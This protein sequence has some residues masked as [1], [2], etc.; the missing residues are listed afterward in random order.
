MRRWRVSNQK[1]LA[2]MLMYPG[3]FVCQACNS[4][5]ESPREL[6][7]VKNIIEDIKEQCD[8]SHHRSH[9]LVLIANPEPLEKSLSTEEPDTP[10]R[11]KKSLSVE[12]LTDTPVRLEKS[13]SVE[14]PDT[15]VRVEKSLSVEKLTDTPVQQISRLPQDLQ[16]TEKSRPANQQISDTT[17]QVCTFNAS[18]LLSR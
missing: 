14:E 15:P 3:L 17:N 1:R 12:E 18:C 13:L 16:P 2:R 11:L 7:S 4:K 10:V 5:L 8:N 6:Y 9:D